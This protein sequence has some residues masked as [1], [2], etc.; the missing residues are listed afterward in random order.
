MNGQLPSIGL[1]LSPEQLSVVHEATLE[2]LSTT[3]FYF[4]CEQVQQVFKKHGFRAQGGRIYFTEKEILRA[5]ETIPKSFTIKGRNP[6]NNVTVDQ[7]STSVGLARGAVYFVESN[8]SFRPAVME[9]VIASLKLAQMMKVLEHV[10]PLAYPS[11][12]DV[13]NVHLWQAQ[14]TI[15]FTDKIYNLTDRHDIDL[16]A[17]AY[18]T[19]R[20]HMIERSDLTRSY[21]HA[22]CIVQSPLGITKNDCDNLVDYA[23][24]GIAFHVASMP[25]AGTSGPCSVGGT[26]VLQNSENLAPIVFS[27]L[28]R[29]GCPAFYGAIAGHAD[30]A[31]LRPRFGTAEAR[32]IERSGC[33][34]AR[35]YGL[36]SRG[37]TGL[38]DAPGYDFQSGA[39]AAFSALSAFS[40]GANFLTGCGLIGSYMGAS[41]SKIVLDT[42]LITMA[43]RY[44]SP[45]D[46]SVSSLAVDVINEIGP[47]GH[48]IEHSHTLENYRSEFPPESIFRSPDYESWRM[49]GKLDAAHFAQERARQIIDS[50]EMPPMD[51]GLEEQIDAYVAAQWVRG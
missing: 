14:A 23:R 25:V 19:N 5:L 28:I 7:N 3:G 34:M 33:Q 11:D 27:Q 1:P 10:G 13:R 45:V 50:Y 43:R 26:I 15:K 16:L 17:I 22:T 24:C 6:N 21:G 9:D 51:T 39:Q 32:V 12:I 2:V 29:P 18:G 49:A 8:G 4:A 44:V 47:G 37:N 41:L 38:T 40:G 46:T 30:M 48:Y 35:Y 36:P 31:S 20:K 42:E